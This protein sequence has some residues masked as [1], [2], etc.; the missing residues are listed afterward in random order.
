MKTKPTN[1]KVICFTVLAQI[2]WKL[3]SC[4]D[5]MCWSGPW[6]R[7]WKQSFNCIHVYVYMCFTLISYFGQK[8]V[9]WVIC[10]LRRNIDLFM[11]ADWNAPILGACSTLTSRDKHSHR[12]VSLQHPKL[13]TGKGEGLCWGLTPAT[14][15]GM[16]HTK[17]AQSP[18]LC[19][20][21]SLTA[22]PLPARL[23]HFRAAALLQFP[24]WGWMAATFE[25]KKLF[26]ERKK[27]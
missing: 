15:R 25:K 5:N 16:G 17:G 23:G 26:F 10:L 3:C 21:Q 4:T 9:T 11:L 24:T 18:Q 14:H 12:M 8:S 13:Q 20:G 2:K 1:R 27:L 22:Q 7:D 6:G 19:Q